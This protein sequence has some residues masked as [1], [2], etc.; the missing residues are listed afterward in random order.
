MAETKMQTEYG[1]IYFKEAGKIH[2]KPTWYLHHKTHKKILA[3]IY[4]EPD[5]NGYAMTFLPKEQFHI[6]CIP[7]IHEFTEQLSNNG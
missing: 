4:W 1:E 3:H 6:D 5:W 7:A 2:G